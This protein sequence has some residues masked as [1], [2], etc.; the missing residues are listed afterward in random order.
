[1]NDRKTSPGTLVKS[2][3]LLR[4]VVHRHEPPV[5]STIPVIHED[6][7]IIV[8]DKPCGLPVHPCGSYNH[9]SLLPLLLTSRPSTSLHTIHRLDRLTSGVVIIGKSSSTSSK[10]SSLIRSEKINKH[11]ILNVKGDFNITSLPGVTPLP[12][13]PCP[14]LKT[15]RTST[16]S[17]TPLTSYTVSL[18]QTCL[19]PKKGIYS[20]TSSPSTSV[21][22]PKSTST[23]FTKISYD[24]VNNTSVVVAEPL[25]GRTHQIRVVVSHLGFGIV[26]DV[27][28][29]R[30]KEGDGD[31]NE[32]GVYRSV[33]GEEVEVGGEGFYCLKGGE[34]G[35]RVEE[36]CPFCRRGGVKAEEVVRDYGKRCEGIRLHAW[37]YW[38]REEDGKVVEYF[39]DVP[40]WAKDS[41]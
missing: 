28:Y 2:N 33:G 39:T 14:T 30:E 6:S 26:G 23:K 29:P 31:N 12:G 21:G 17:S 24:D 37:G 7:E 20:I 15:F 11:Y 3:D 35:R 34:M 9:N 40:K 25:T 4:H 8:V 18:N 41:I 1:M 38:W 19:D 13:L 16:L 5:P 27:C 32:V 10:L 22:W 36:V